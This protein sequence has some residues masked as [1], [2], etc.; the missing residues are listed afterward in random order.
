MANTASQQQG[1]TLGRS[2]VGSVF[3][4]IGLAGLLVAIISFA[5]TVTIAPI[6]LIALIVGLVGM[7][8]WAAV[9]PKDFVATLTGKQARHGTV[10][11]FASLLLLGIVV[12][13]YIIIARANIAIDTTLSR[14]FSLTD[15]T[16]DVLDRIP[17]GR[18]LQ[19]TGFYTS[20][21]LE[22]RALD[23]QFLRQYELQT[24][25]RVVVEYINPQEQ[26]AVAQRFGVIQNGQL[27]VS[28]LDE[29]G[30]VDFNAV[31]AVPR[32]NKQERDI[33][34]AILSLLNQQVL[35]V[36]FAQDRT[37]LSIFD[38]TASGITLMDNGLRFNGI[39]TEAISLQQLA[40]AGEA[41]P[42]D[43]ATLVL[44]RPRLALGEPELAVIDD[45]LQRG[46]SL[47][48]LADATSNENSFLQQESAFNAYLTENYGLVAFDGVVVDPPMQVETPLD[49]IPAAIFGEHPTGAAIPQGQDPFFRIARPVLASEQK[50]ETVANG[51]IMSSSQQSY[52]ER[53]L[54]TLFTTNEF[55]FDEET[56]LTGPADL[57]VW[58]WDEQGNGSKVI[59]IGD[60]DFVRNRNI[61]S[62]TVG[63]A[64]LFTESIRWLSGRE[65]SINFG[66]VANPSGL[67]VLFV[68]GG[69][70]DL[71]GIFTV[72]IV[73]LAV[74]FIGIIVWYR[75]TF[76]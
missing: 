35:K 50:P 16:F 9:A 48:V 41:I 20:D 56:D 74:L 25:G 21:A 36:Y 65:D 46:G 61:D 58:A 15:A 26:P 73:P 11:V 5:W 33:T 69:N 75:R 12:L 64:A 30:N 37:S 66:F 13:S 42:E 43:A 18:T 19:I 22:E 60:G 4:F 67:P 55:A 2:A 68:S 14:T 3:G 40:A 23:D 29:N 10:S 1:V 7:V 44:P 63:N 38:E 28:L 32:E 24:S 54:E 62:G 27:F 39:Q 57:V 31:A 70:L 71:I 17:E 72:A 6:T 76:A 52:I 53:D 34:N 49:I 47:L 59:L 8:A 51:R 45:Y